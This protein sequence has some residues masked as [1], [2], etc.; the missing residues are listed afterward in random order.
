M[1]TRLLA[2]LLALVLAVPLAGCKAKTSDAPAF[3]REEEIPVKATETL[4]LGE[5][6]ILCSTPTNDVSTPPIDGRRQSLLIERLEQTILKQRNI[7]MDIVLERVSGRHYTHALQ[8]V[9]SGDLPEIVHVF[10]RERTHDPQAQTLAPVALDDAVNLYGPNL[11]KVPDAALT[12]CRIGGQLV[13]LPRLWPSFDMPVLNLQVLEQHGWD[14]PETL[15]ELDA[16]LAKAKDAGIQPI[17]EMAYNIEIELLP[18]LNIWNPQVL[19]AEDG[20][21]LPFYRTALFQQATDLIKGWWDAGY[22]PKDNSQHEGF[23]YLANSDWLMTAVGLTSAA[24]VKGARLLPL[25]LTGEQGLTLGGPS[26]VSAAVLEAY[27]KPEALV[28]LM[29]WSLSKLENHL[30]MTYGQEV[31]D[32]K[33]VDDN[34]LEAV[35]DAYD[36]FTTLFDASWKYPLPLMDC[37]SPKL[38]S[39]YQQAAAETLQAREDSNWVSLPSGAL[40]YADST[41]DLANALAQLPDTI[42]VCSDLITDRVEAGLDWGTLEYPPAEGDEGR[43]SAGLAAYDVAYEP[44]LRLL[45]SWL[46]GS[47]D[48]TGDMVTPR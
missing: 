45:Q 10:D 36:R 47:Y 18:F 32:Y 4:K 14:A 13:S 31:E 37:E 34:R 38:V 26:N 5:V 30:F 42:T 29:D 12:G 16:L 39:A 7:D 6:Q 19:R 22:F 9:A 35:G 8:M 25:S 20:T 44:Y 48:P 21:L 27:D 46:N 41:G 24:T 28:T 33:Q 2:L 3:L 1:R 40:R 11:A 17:D 43:V 15:E 23:A